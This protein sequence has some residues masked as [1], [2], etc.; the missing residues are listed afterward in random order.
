MI[1]QGNHKFLK[2]LAYLNEN[3]Y[4]CGIQKGI[5]TPILSTYL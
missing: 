3:L 1:F 2:K 5:S 4:F